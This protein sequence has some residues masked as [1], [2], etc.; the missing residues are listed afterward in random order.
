MKLDKEWKDKR[1]ME[2]TVQTCKFCGATFVGEEEA[3]KHLEVCLLNVLDNSSCVTCKYVVI[4]KE[5]PTSKRNGYQSSRLLNF[6]GSKDYITCGK[7]IYEG[8]MLEDK[9]LRENK[10]CFSRADFDDPFEVFF[11]DNYKRWEKLSQQA[12]D[13]QNELEEEIID[14]RIK[15][16]KLTEEMKEHGYTDEEI[17]LEIEKLFEEED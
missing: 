10:S 6:L 12:V 15:I 16:G 11:T 13:E 2:E 7:G 8:K 9:I 5:A 17:A 4:N 3:K 1:L 14:D